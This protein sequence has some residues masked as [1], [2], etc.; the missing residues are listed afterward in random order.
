MTFSVCASLK[1]KTKQPPHPPKKNN[2]NKNNNN[3][4][5]VFSL[6]YPNNWTISQRFFLFSISL[7]KSKYAD[8]FFFYSYLSAWMLHNI[9]VSISSILYYNV[10]LPKSIC[11]CL[12]CRQFLGFLCNGYIHFPLLQQGYPWPVIAIYLQR[13][14]LASIFW[15]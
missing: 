3:Y 1:N 12:I 8:S 15:K 6:Q 10:T 9:I 7:S 14:L 2:Y 13:R 11:F 4:K 5:Q